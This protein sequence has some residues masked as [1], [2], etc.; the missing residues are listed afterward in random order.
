M[1]WAAAVAPNAAYETILAMLNV[2]PKHEE[3]LV[4][5]FLGDICTDPHAGFQLTFDTGITK[6]G[7]VVAALIASQKKPKPPEAFG[8]GYK[9]VT[10]GVCDIANPS[11]ADD[12]KTAQLGTAFNLTGFC[13]LS[14][15]SKF[16]LN[17]P[18]GH[19][20]RY[21]I[22][23]ITSCEEK[24]SAGASQPGVKT[25][26]M[27]K[28]QIV[29]QADA[30]KA[31]HVFQR[32]RRLTMRVNPSNE[33]ERKHTLVVDEDCTTPLKKCRTLHAVPSDVSLG[34]KEPADTS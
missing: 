15:M 32:L 24:A 13:T 2:L 16:D 22:A 4:F 10:P 23:F 34:D 20:Q 7:A 1:N 21:A 29:E 25:F 17:P 31:I 12:S 8:E 6:K 27:D 5:G 26:H 9:V 18:R 3:G 33:Q 30:P 28:L 19:K 11:T 14:D